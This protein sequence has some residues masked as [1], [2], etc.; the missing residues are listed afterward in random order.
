MNAVDAFPLLRLKACLKLAEVSRDA[1]RSALEEIGFTDE[2][3]SA[4]RSALS[5]GWKMK[6][7]IIKAM[8]SKAN[9][10]LLDEVMDL[11][12]LCLLLFLLL[13]SN[14]MFPVNCSLRITWTLPLCSG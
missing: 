8:L 10:L 9:V 14:E 11:F 4:P 3:L 2:M 12:S 1:A 6:L 7:L 5:G 13:V